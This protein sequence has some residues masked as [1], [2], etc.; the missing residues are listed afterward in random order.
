MLPEWKVVGYLHHPFRQHFCFLIQFLS[1]Q[2]FFCVRSYCREKTVL[3]IYR[4][5]EVIPVVA[6]L[7]CIIA[8]FCA[9]T[10]S[11]ALSVCFCQF[12]DTIGGFRVVICVYKP[13]C[14]IHRKVIS[15][16]KAV[17]Q[18]TIGVIVER[19]CIAIGLQDGWRFIF[20]NA[21]KNFAFGIFDILVRPVNPKKTGDGEQN[22]RNSEQNNETYHSSCN[23]SEP[24]LKK[25][26]HKNHR[27]AH[28]IT[29]ISRSS[30]GTGRYDFLTI[31]AVT[32]PLVSRSIWIW[33]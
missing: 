32:R 3:I 11:I 5:L 6:N 31:P 28:T 26:L 13:I 8:I 7:L 2:P 1:S 21:G 17:V 18:E 4:A 23:D 30:K 14:I 33:T 20:Q 15:L 24:L 16:V 29:Q 27:L 25:F 22:H 10:L 19:H 12:F 9:K